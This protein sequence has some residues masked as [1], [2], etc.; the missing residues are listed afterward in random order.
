[1]A[2]SLS[3]ITGSGFHTQQHIQLGMVVNTSNPSTWKV[4]LSNSKFKVSLRYKVSSRP[5]CVIRSWEVGDPS[6]VVSH[7]TTE[8]CSCSQ[9]TQ[10][11]G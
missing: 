4:E 10:T 9:K 8:V 1:M 5:A 6:I 3:S 11:R 7:I 2:E